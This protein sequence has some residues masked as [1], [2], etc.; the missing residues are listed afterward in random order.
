[1]AGEYGYVKMSRKAYETDP[2]WSEP[3]AFSRWE[4]W[5]DLIQMAAWRD[6]RRVV[7][8][9]VLDVRRGEVLASLRFLA[10]RWKWSK[11]KVAAF[12]DL[13]HEMGRIKGQRETQ[14][15]TVYLLVN[16]DRYQS[17]GTDDGTQNGTAEG[18]E[19][20]SEGTAKG[21]REGSKE[22]KDNPPPPSPRSRAR[23][24]DQLAEYLGP[25]AAA[26]ERF[27]A[28]A[29]HSPTWPAAIIGLYGPSGT[30]PT[31]WQRSP[32]VADADRPMLLARAMDRYAAEGHQYDNRYFRRFLERV[33]DEHEQGNDQQASD[34]PRRPAT[35]GRGEAARRRAGELAHLG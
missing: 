33:I 9:A 7:G 8:M 28:A 27:A 2:F 16:Y 11:N 4:A 34:H 12:L 26:A 1:M 10:T 31:I 13:L 3:R 22:E 23:G 17:G 32:P 15:G 29:D 14:A 25:H 20:D 21:Q 30:D 24:L 5:E 19:G 6:H 18:R 35:H